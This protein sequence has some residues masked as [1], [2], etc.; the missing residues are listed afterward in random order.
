MGGG[1][2]REAAAL[3]TSSPLLD[4]GGNSGPSCSADAPPDHHFNNGNHLFPCGSS[5]ELSAPSICESPSFL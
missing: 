1:Y 4:R 5:N 2:A 3:T